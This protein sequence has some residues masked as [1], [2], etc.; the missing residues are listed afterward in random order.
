M[1]PKDRQSYDFEPSTLLWNKVR[2]RTDF[3]VRSLTLQ[4]NVTQK[5]KEQEIYTRETTEIATQEHTKPLNI[6]NDLYGKIV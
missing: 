3:V 5:E 1:D 4:K 6:R 2:M